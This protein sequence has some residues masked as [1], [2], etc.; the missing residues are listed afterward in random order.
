MVEYEPS[1]KLSAVLVNHGDFSFL[2]VML[3][4]QSLDF[5]KENLNKIE[6]TL[7]K[8]LVYKCLYDMV[9]IL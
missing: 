4:A 1:D 2:K 6:D 8:S 7:I 9:S 5:F 3:D